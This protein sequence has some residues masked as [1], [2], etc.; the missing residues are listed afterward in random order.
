MPFPATPVL[1]SEVF[2]RSR[3]RAAPCK[4]RKVRGP[5]TAVAGDSPP[6]LGL[7][8][9]SE[10]SRRTPGHVLVRGSL[11]AVPSSLEVFGARHRPGP[12]PRLLPQAWTTLQGMTLRPSPRAPESPRPPSWGSAPLQRSRPAESALPG[13]SVARHVPSP[14]FPTPSTVSSSA[15]SR[16]F[17]GRCRS[18]GSPFRALLLPGKTDASRR[19]CSHAVSSNPGPPL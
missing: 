4:V 9:L 12:W 2:G 5:R 1:H 15:G 14:A 16:P 3:F 11:R 7:P 13:R 10:R 6:L 19:R 17:S 8:C 18:W